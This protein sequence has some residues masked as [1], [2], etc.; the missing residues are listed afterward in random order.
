MCVFHLLTIVLPYAY[1]FTSLL[2]PCVNSSAISGY[3]SISDH[4]SKAVI[5]EVC[6]LRLGVESGVCEALISPLQVLQNT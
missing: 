1:G 2:I 4:V 5:D 3:V 6:G